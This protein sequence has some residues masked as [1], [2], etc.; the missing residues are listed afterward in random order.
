MFRVW[1]TAITCVVGGRSEVHSG[2]RIRTKYK[3]KCGFR[4][5]VVQVLQPTVDLKPPA[6]GHV[7][8]AGDMVQVRL[9]TEHATNANRC[10]DKDGTI[11]TRTELDYLL[12]LVAS[13]QTIQRLLTPIW[14]P[15]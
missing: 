6:A 10:R 7:A 13:D 2:E 8:T 5:D 3:I 4:S 12:D 9:A 14:R 11:L 15:P 1:Q